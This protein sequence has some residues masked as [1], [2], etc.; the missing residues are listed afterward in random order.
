MASKKVDRRRENTRRIGK[1]AV[2]TGSSKR[3]Y[4]AAQV[5]TQMQLI[6]DLWIEGASDREIW[7]A[8]AKA[9]DEGKLDSPLSRPRVRLLRDRVQKRVLEE[10]ETE[11]PFTKA[12]QARRLT[13]AIRDCK[14]V[15]DAKGVWLRKPDHM[16]RA[17]YED[18]IAR[19]EGNYEPIR[20]EVDAVHRQAVADV[21]AGLTEE[22]LK[23]YGNAFDRMVELAESK[24]KEV[25]E[26]LA[27]VLPRPPLHVNGA[28]GTGTTA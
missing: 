19:V 15:Q 23:R 24:A 10:T 16:S 18:M 17:R 9:Y 14:G 8:C 4:T 1:E 13:R 11:R 2:A 21:I 20:I 3:R 5:A 6:G 28:N 12:R 27:D 25:G 26:N 22:D 7:L